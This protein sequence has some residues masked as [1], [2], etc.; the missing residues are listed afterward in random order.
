MSKHLLIVWAD[1]KS[2]SG[3]NE[4]RNSNSQPTKEQMSKHLLIVWADAKSFSGTNEIRNSLLTKN[5]SIHGL[6]T[7]AERRHAPDFADYGPDVGQPGVWRGV[8][9][10]RR[11]RFFVLQRHSR[12]E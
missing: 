3:T 5:G 2:F 4:I 12:A 7:H 9:A 11:N 10:R 1:A 6:L 8:D